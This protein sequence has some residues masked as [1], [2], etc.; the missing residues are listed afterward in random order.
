V[1]NQKDISTLRV[2]MFMIVT[3][4][5]LKILKVSAMMF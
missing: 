2:K 1:N 5:S 3:L 4:N